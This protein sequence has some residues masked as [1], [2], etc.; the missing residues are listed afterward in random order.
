MRVA[1]TTDVDG[2]ARIAGLLSAAG[3]EPVLLP[4]VRF[5]RAPKGTVE[6]VRDAARSADWV[7]A[8]SPRA[9]RLVWPEGM[10]PSPP[11][12][13]VGPVTAAAA[14]RLGATVELVGEAG[15]AALAEALAP[16]AAG[17]TVVHPAAAGSDPA[18]IARLRAAGA[19]VITETIYSM[20]PVAPAADPVD[21]ALFGSPSAVTG[22]LQTRS[23]DELA[24]VAAIGPTTAATLVAA[25]RSPDIVPPHARHRG[26]GRRPRRRRPI[27]REDHRMSSFPTSRQ[28][29]LRRSAA[30]RRAVAETRLHPASF[31]LPL[32]VVPGTGTDRPIAAMPGHSQLSADRAADLAKEAEAVGVGGVILFG[33]P[34]TKDDTGSSAWDPQGPV[35]A[36][37]RAIKSA[38]PDL[39]VWADVCLCEYTSHGH[40]GVLDGERVDNDATLPLLARAAL[41]YAD[42]GADIIAPSDMMDGRVAAIRSALDGAGHAELADLLVLGQ[43][44]QRLLRPVPRRR[45]IDPGVRRPP[46]PPDGP[47]QRPGGAGRGAP[48]PGRGRRHGDGQAGRP[49]PRRHRRRPRL[50]SDVPVAAYQ[51]S[52]EYSHHRGCRRQRAGWTA[53]VL[54]MESLTGI[55][56]AGAGIILT[57]F[58]VRAARRLER[59]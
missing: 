18:P 40:C 43:V 35:P 31:V 50:R 23:T 4:C 56:R 58:A 45:R 13:A 21:A 8:T 11:V 53:I 5:D 47:G 36:A 26:R 3:L 24:V 34:T 10:P 48:G 2:A 52:G 32:F 38:A 51:V 59:E 33:I 55:A 46:H 6:K 25:G 39:A 16:R 30:I 57:Y 49:V 42:A 27:R 19:V 9:L 54:M 20:T 14:T 37:I 1:V 28:R 22:W 7:L 44:R 41:A 15:A 12:A 29:R 17:A